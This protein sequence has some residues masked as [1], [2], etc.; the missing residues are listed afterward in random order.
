M[1]PSFVPSCCKGF[2][3]AL[4]IYRMS[5]FFVL[6]GFGQRLDDCHYHLL[7]CSYYEALVTALD[8]QGPHKTLTTRRDEGRRHT[9]NLYHLDAP[10]TLQARRKGT[11]DKPPG[12]SQNP[13]NR[14][15]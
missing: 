5:P 7:P 2:V 3:R 15:E 14:K 8:L 9:T 12:P 6:V 10:Q 11:Y 13:Y 1:C 4:Q